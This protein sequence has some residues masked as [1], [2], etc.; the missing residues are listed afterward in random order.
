[1]YRHPCTSMYSFLTIPVVL[2]ED[3][4]SDIRLDGQDGKWNKMEHS[5]RSFRVF[6]FV[7]TKSKV[8][9]ADLYHPWPHEMPHGQS[10]IELRHGSTWRDRSHQ[11]RSAFWRA[12]K[13]AQRS[14]LSC[15]IT[16]RSRHGRN[17]RN[18][19]HAESGRGR[20]DVEGGSRQ[21]YERRR[22]FWLRPR[23][24]TTK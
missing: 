14:L 5:E 18:H 11:I 2:F 4:G 20:L 9:E 12:P 15:L 23:I 21:K 19:R 3:M 13:V 24:N 6:L 22:C 17:P 10:L 8:F 16:L 7:G 1:M